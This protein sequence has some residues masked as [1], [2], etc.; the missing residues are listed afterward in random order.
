MCSPSAGGWLIMQSAPVSMGNRTCFR[1]GMRPGAAARMMARSAVSGWARAAARSLTGP[2][3]TPAAAIL[4]SQVCAVPVRNRPAI[5][6]A[7]SDR[8]ATRSETVRKRGSAASSGISS[9][10]QSRAKSRSVAAAI[11]IVP[12]A[13]RNAS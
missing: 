12:S 10:W 9:A 5:T 7:S 8:V 6:S 1:A 3:G 13:V 2:A 4:A 11:M